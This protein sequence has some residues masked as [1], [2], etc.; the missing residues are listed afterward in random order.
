MQQN[1]Y[2]QA[3]IEEASFEVSIDDEESLASE[4]FLLYH[5]VDMLY[6]VDLYSGPSDHVPERG[7]NK[8]LLESVELSFSSSLLIGI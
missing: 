6:V 7:G 8:K 1:N 3:A 5:G 4:V 2:K